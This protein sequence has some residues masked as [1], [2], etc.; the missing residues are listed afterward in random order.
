MAVRVKKLLRVI[1]SAEGQVGG[2]VE[3]IRVSYPHLKRLGW[4]VDLVTADKCNSALPEA[5]ADNVFCVGTGKKGFG[6][7]LKFYRWVRENVGDYDV[8]LTHGLWQYACLA[9]SSACIAQ[10]VPYAVFTHGMLDRWF[11]LDSVKWFKKLVYWT[12]FERSR[13]NAAVCVLYTTSRE[14]VESEKAF[15]GY[16]AHGH[17]IRYGVA[18]I[19]ELAGPHRIVSNPDSGIQRLLFLGR[20]HPK[21]GCLELIK[22]LALLP[23]D[24]NVELRVAGKGEASYERRLRKAASNLPLNC[25]I[26]WLGDV[27]G[28]AKCEEFLQADFFCLPSYQENFGIAV[29]EA[30]AAGLPVIVSNGVY[31]SSEIEASGAG[32]IVNPTIDSLVNGLAK[33]LSMPEKERDEMSVAAR[34]LFT[35][36]YTADV[37]AEELSAI[38]ERS[39]SDP[40]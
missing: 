34:R 30:L 31:I 12:F 33:A 5:L 2:P 8:V 3:G 1:Q 32:L 36:R 10:G 26:T 23:D 19:K 4:Q 40:S 29:A 18:P 38:L 22:A 25:R 9:A 13:I 39:I 28:A 24:C 14:L 21:K 20:L 17:V 37:A 27:R 15:Y 6:R 16:K 7:S 35:C 11:N